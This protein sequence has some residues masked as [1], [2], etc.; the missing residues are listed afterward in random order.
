VGVIGTVLGTVAGLALC[1]VQI[2]FQLIKLPGDVY[3]ISTLPMIVNYY[4]VLA[5][6]A[7]ANALAI[8][9][10]FYPAVKA[11]RLKPVEALVY[12]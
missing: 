6:V 5:V 12:K 4:D 9:F 2:K 8:L 10:S 7:T 3:F 11:A 1:F